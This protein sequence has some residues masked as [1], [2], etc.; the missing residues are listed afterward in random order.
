[1]SGGVCRLGETSA[2][3]WPST[4]YGDRMPIASTTPA[5]AAAVA[6]SPDAEVDDVSR[7]TIDRDRLSGQATKFAIA[8]AGVAAIGQ[9][10]A[11]VIIGRLAERPDWSAVGQLA[12]CVVGAAVLDTVGRVAWSSVIDRAEGQ[13]RTDLLDSVMRQPVSALTEQAVGEILD[14]IDDDTHELGTL[15]RMSAWRVIRLALVALPL[16]LV[17]GLTWWPAWLLLPATTAVVF[18]V[19]RPLL[20]PLARCKV[21]EEAAWTDHAA[22]M[23]EG[24]AARDDLRT[25]LGQ[26]SEERV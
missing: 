20:G 17:A 14:R 5:A 13:L 3:R 2:G 18:A 22:A 12:L 25:S 21:A 9:A 4:S 23:E 19:V 10:F 7:R 8:M 24:I 1:M 26:R 11:A 15:L 6:V 16:L